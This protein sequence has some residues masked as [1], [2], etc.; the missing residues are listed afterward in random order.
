[1]FFIAFHIWNTGHNCSFTVV[2]IDTLRLALRLWSFRVSMKCVCN[3]IKIQ[4]QVSTIHS[5]WDGSE[6]TT[7]VRFHFS[8]EVALHDFPLLVNVT[9]CMLHIDMKLKLFSDVSTL[10]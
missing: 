2:F 7:S 5:Q 1:M 8:S 4:T 6:N 10:Y 3:G 9:P